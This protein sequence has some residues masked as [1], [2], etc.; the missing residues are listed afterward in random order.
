MDPVRLRDGRRLELEPVL[1][2]IAQPVH[3]DDLAGELARATRDAREQAVRA[4]ESP[5]HG[6]RLGR[7]ARVL[8][9]LDDRRE[10]TV[11]V[12]EERRPRGLG[13]KRGERVHAP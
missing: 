3:A 7:H 1:P 10:H 4:S 6:L 8:G 12:Q 9:P 11:H 13:G 5:Q 2:D